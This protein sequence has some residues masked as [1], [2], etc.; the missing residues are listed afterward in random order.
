MGVRTLSPC[1]VE[2]VFRLEHLVPRG[3]LSFVSEGGLRGVDLGCWAGMLVEV[4]CI[5]GA[6]NVGGSTVKY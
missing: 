2:V 6:P 4:L 1:V 5:Y 3:T